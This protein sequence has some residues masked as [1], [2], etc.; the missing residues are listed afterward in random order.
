MINEINDLRE[1]LAK[2]AEKT[3]IEKEAHIQMLEIMANIVPDSMKPL[4]TLPVKVS[5]V[6]DKVNDIM[7]FAPQ[8]EDDAEYAIKACEFLDRVAEACV[9][10]LEQAKDAGEQHGSN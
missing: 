7:M 6:T 9:A 5:R 1:K 2:N 10:F 3:R 4:F 8:A